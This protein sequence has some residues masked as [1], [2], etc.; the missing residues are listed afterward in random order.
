MVGENDRSLGVENTLLLR[1]RPKQKN[2]GFLPPFVNATFCLRDVLSPSPR[3]GKWIRAA[4]LVHLFDASEEVIEFRPAAQYLKWM[5]QE[6]RTDFS[7]ILLRPMK[8]LARETHHDLR[9]RLV[10]WFAIPTRAIKAIG[11]RFAD[12]LNGTDAAISTERVSAIRQRS[13]QSIG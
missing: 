10:R 13:F 9:N 11:I 6:H 2:I 12:F 1:G 8:P 5:T 7:S 3:N 4:L